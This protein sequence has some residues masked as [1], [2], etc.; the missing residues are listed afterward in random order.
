VARNFPFRLNA[1]EFTAPVREALK[2][3]I[4]RPVRTSHNRAVPSTLAV[5]MNLPFRLKAMPFTR[6][7][8]AI[9]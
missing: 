2:T 8:P 4:W 9:N 3:P 1:S 5:A 6:A 7:C